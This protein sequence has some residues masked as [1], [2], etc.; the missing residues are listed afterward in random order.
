MDPRRPWANTIFDNKIV[1]IGA[2]VLR[3]FG[4]VILSVNLVLDTS[5]AFLSTFTS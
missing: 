1:I 3:I 5:Y 2:Y 4:A